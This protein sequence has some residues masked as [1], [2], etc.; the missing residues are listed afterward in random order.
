MTTPDQVP[1]PDVEDA[2][3]LSDVQIKARLARMLAS[4]VLAAARKQCRCAALPSI[5]AEP[6]ARP[7]HN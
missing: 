3:E 1:A 6:Q 2:Q 5:E 7:I 4:G